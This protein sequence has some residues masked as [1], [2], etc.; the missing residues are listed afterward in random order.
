MPTRPGSL[1][2]GI[3]SARLVGIGVAGGLA[4]S[5]LL[6][7]P[8]LLRLLPGP[9]AAH[10]VEMAILSLLGLDAAARAIAGGRTP[11]T[12]AVAPSRAAIGWLNPLADRALRWGLPGALAVICGALWIAWMPQYLTWPWARDPDTFATLAQGW[13]AGIRPYRDVLAYNFP[14]AIYLAWIVGKV[15]GWGQTAALYAVDALVVLGLGV[16]LVAWS[17]RCLGGALPGLVGYL[18]FL[19]FYLG[20]TYE[21]VAQR[22]WYAALGAALALLV[23]QTDPS[24]RG[25]LAAAAFW[26]VALSFRPQAILFLPALTAAVVLAVRE[27]DRRKWR[28]L[29]ALGEWG[30]ALG[31]AA[32]LAFL[33]LLLA[34]L[35]DD[36]FRNLRIVAYGGPYSQASPAGMVTTFLDQFRHPPTVFALVA[37]VLMAWLGPPGLRRTARPWALAWPAVLLYAP[38]SPVQH[39]YLVHPLALFG[40]ISL[41]MP[42]AWLIGATRLPGPVR[43]LVLALGLCLIW[44]GVPRFCSPARSL[45]ALGP[46]VRGAEPTVPPLGSLNS[47]PRDGR[48][49]SHWDCYCDVLRYLRAR[50][51]PQ[52]P[53][54]NA[55]NRP[56]FESINGPTGRLSPFLA[57]SGVCWLSW[58]AIDLDGRFATALERTPGAVVVW[59]PRSQDPRRLRLDRVEAVIRQHYRFEARFGDIE[60]WRRADAPKPP[61]SEAADAP[62]AARAERRSAYR[63]P[64]PVRRVAS[65]CPRSD[66]RPGGSAWA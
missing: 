61:E 51:D 33:P 31:L 3:L 34:G 23:L 56:P 4:V 66:Q 22:D 57:E 32:V 17:G 65:S 52:T 60:V 47:F 26:A 44:P 28:A 39:N 55:L 25:R 24:R 29:N 35:L 43:V 12:A 2:A 7:V 49:S 30:L 16:A 53:V 13:D 19:G 62:W 15:A 11:W 36:L 48:V 6:V 40:A 38:I 59:S 18:M 46:L 10:R 9:L 58:V 21:V 50:T 37:T 8:D 20:L 45:A 41:A 63:R 14:G 5:V 27:T 42:V 54:A 1:G 64:S